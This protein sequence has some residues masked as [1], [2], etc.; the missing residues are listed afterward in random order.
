MLQCDVWHRRGRFARTCFVRLA[1]I[2]GFARLGV[3]GLDGFTDAV[4]ALRCERSSDSLTSLDASVC[5][6]LACITP[7][8]HCRA[9]RESRLIGTPLT[10]A[11]VPIAELRLVLECCKRLCE[12]EL[13]NVE[14]ELGAIEVRE[15]V[16]GPRNGA[17]GV[18]VTI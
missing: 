3:R 18:V 9:L 13:G 14:L 5:E 10:S 16:V 1:S 11:R 2:R 4:L 8:V 12:P 7:L 6:R 15:R 17:D